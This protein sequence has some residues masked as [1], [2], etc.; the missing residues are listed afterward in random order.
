MKKISDKNF[1][2]VDVCKLFMAYVVIAIHTNPFINID[3]QLLVNIFIVLEDFAVP[4]FFITSGFFLKIS[5]DKHDGD[6]FNQYKKYFFK[7]L[8]MYVVWTLVSL[9]LTIYGYCISG[10]GILH[11]ILS[12]IKY[13]F[14]VGK[15]YNS[16]HLWYLL[17]L[18]Y[19]V[20]FI[21]LLRKMRFS[22]Y[23]I[24][25]I[26]IGMYLINEC[27]SYLS[28]QID[29][30]IDFINKII[31]IYQYVFNKG[32][33]FTGTV[34]VCIGMLIAEKMKVINS[35]VCIVSLVIINVVQFNV[36]A[37]ICSVMNIIEAVFFFM[38]IMQIKLPKKEYYTMCR[39]MS[40]NIYLVHLIVFS[41]YTILVIKT[42]N[43]LGVDSF[44]AVS[45]FSSIIAYIM[46][47]LKR[48]I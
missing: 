43:K 28:L 26:A 17:A 33:I 8:K 16:Y 21:W 42:P 34:Y 46:V 10:E 31:D 36:N 22:K 14:F 40:I 41:V 3:N 1:C 38:L 19:A 25:V 35:F 48:A 47:K 45:I 44:V 6:E 27:I 24:L 13:F 11:C 9:P 18:L 5:I 39:N 2:S 4:F 30:N 23:A 20:I 12:Y 32:G 7:I 29:G 37:N 15:L